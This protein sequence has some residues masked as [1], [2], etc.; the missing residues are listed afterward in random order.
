MKKLVVLILMSASFSYASEDFDCCSSLE[1][2]KPYYIIYSEAYMIK[3][4][5]YGLSD[6]IPEEEFKEII[7]R[8][9]HIMDLSAIKMP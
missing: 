3:D 6:V 9:K 5:I 2:I 4:V 1:E 7:G 8:V